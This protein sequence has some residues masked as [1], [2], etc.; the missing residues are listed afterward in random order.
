MNLAN[1]SLYI[2][3]ADSHAMLGY[4]YNGNYY[5]THWS[6]RG[7]IPLTSLES[8]G[9]SISKTEMVRNKDNVVFNV[10]EA[11]KEEREHFLNAKTIK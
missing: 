11:S 3:M 5:G 10:R 7:P 4:L 2:V 6:E 8:E 9:F 1:D